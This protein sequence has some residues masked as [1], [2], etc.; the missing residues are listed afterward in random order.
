MA[1]VTQQ[2]IITLAAGTAGGVTTNKQLSTVRINAL[3]VMIR[4]RSTN[5]DPVR[6][7]ADVFNRTTQT[8]TRPTDPLTDSVATLIEAGEGISMGVVSDSSK[9]GELYD[10]SRYWVQGTSGDV[11][12]IWYE[13]VAPV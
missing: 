5:T 10:L 2:I 4:A 9:K 12:E 8:F 7:A 11:L 1:T 13:M 6:F 3:S